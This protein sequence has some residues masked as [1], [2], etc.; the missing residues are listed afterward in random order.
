MPRQSE[1][2]YPRRRLI[3]ALLRLV[4]VPVFALTS[5]MEII[6]QENLPQK[7]PMLLVANHFSFID[8][9][10]FVRIARWPIE[11]LGGAEF[12]H[13]PGW[14]KAIPSLWGYYP[15]YRGTGSTYALKAAESILGQGGIM[16][17]FPEAG[18]WAEVLRP[19]RPGTAFLA[20]LTGSPL[21][22]VGIHG[23]NNI[24]PFLK[25]GQRAQVTVRIGKPFGPFQVTGRGRERRQQLDEIGHEIMR[26]I[27]AL[28]PPEKR[29]HYS[30]DPAI[31]AA[32]QGTELYPW[33][34]K[35]EGEFIGEVH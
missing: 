27:A 10:T 9:V 20:T 7:G 21:L 25:K 24:F 13:A 2:K 30:D 6:G 28:L 15:L 17:I 18:N 29:G 34:D 26:H 23:L 14:A 1:F 22:P 32:A 3:R 31:R 11:F 16:G 19:A 4:S 12:A 33:A 8:P 5:R 35:V